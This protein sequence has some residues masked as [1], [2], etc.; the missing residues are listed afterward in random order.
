MPAAKEE[1]PL[2]RRRLPGRSTPPSD[3]S[4]DSG[5]GAAYAPVPD[6]TTAEAAPSPPD[7][8]GFA[9]AKV[10]MLRLLGLVYCVAFLGARWQNGESA[11]PCRPHAGHRQQSPL[12]ASLRPHRSDW[13]VPPI[14]NILNLGWP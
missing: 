14:A 7:P 9:T 4:S 12:P 11:L 5:A 1:V 3:E 2:M 13:G 6:A 8:E 10:W